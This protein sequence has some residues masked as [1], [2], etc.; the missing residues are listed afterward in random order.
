[1]SGSEINKSTNASRPSVSVV[2]PFYNS[3]HTL[4]RALNSIAAQTHSVTETIIVDDASTSE[5][6]AIAEAVVASFPNTRLVQF[7]RNCGPSA[8]RNRGVDE[9]RGEFVAFLDADDQW[10]SNKVEVCLNLMQQRQLAFLGHNA[11]IAGRTRPSVNDGLHPFTTLYRMN[12]VD[13]SVSTSQFAPSTVIFRKNMIP[14]KFDESLRLSEDYR[15]WGELILRGHAL[16]KL[17]D[18]L[19]SRDEPHIKGRGLSGDAHK[20]LAAHLRTI[21]YFGDKGF[22]SKPVAWLMDCFLRLKYL[23]HR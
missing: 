10:L 16:W 23:R 20:L 5:Q 2:I 13:I 17:K 18:F 21:A 12:W 8:A 7:E 14:V 22:V 15:L 11:V 9:A 4:Q 6:A 3:A 19:S 1:M